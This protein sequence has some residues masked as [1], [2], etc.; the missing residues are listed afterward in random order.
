MKESMFSLKEKQHNNGFPTF[1]LPVST[2]NRF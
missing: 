1:K 2:T